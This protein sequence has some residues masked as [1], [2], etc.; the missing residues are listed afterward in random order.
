MT[1]LPL[2]RMDTI[3]DQINNGMESTLM[4][5]RGKISLVEPEGR[6]FMQV[7]VLKRRGK[8]QFNA[9]VFNQKASIFEKLFSRFIKA[10]AST[11][12]EAFVSDASTIIDMAFL[13]EN[14]QCFVEHPF[15]LHAMYVMFQQAN[16]LLGNTIEANSHLSGNHKLYGFKSEASVLASGICIYLSGHAKGGEPDTSIFCRHQRNHKAMTKKE[17]GELALFDI[18]I[19]SANHWAVLADKGCHGL[20]SDISIV[21]S[22]TS[23][24]WI[25]IL[26]KKR[27]LIETSIKTDLL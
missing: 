5:G 20:Q 7:C 12:Y 27:S 17:E 16:R 8:G 24:A 10:A 6:F 13:R 25:L 22:K 15:A 23:A 3:Q 14:N 18:E 9:T 19:S 4:K 2:A 11:M 26:L 1:N 21:P